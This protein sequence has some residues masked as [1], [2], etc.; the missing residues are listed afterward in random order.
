LLYSEAVTPFP[1]VN[2]KK[3][4]KEM[5]SGLSVDFIHTENIYNDYEKQPLLPH[6]LTASGPDIAVGD[7]NNDGLD[8]FFIGNALNSKGAMFLQAKNGSF[9]RLQVLGK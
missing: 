3:L 4:F 7:V 6:K 1:V 9:N 8:D 5:A 2:P